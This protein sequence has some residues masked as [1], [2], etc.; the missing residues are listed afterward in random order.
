M[1]PSVIYDL[2]VTCKVTGGNSLLDEVME[3]RDLMCFSVLKQ[4]FRQTQAMYLG[5][6][7]DQDT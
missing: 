4:E 2:R 3:E 7:V 5:N 1:Y 6:V